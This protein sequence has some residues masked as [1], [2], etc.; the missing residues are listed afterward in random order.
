MINFDR[1]FEGGAEFL[2]RWN[3]VFDKPDAYVALFTALLFVS[4]V[5]LWLATRG[6]F[7]I[8]RDSTRLARQEFNA[9]HRPKIKVHAAELKRFPPETKRDEDDDWDRLGA[10][11]VC[12]NIGESAA[13]KIEIRGQILA[14]AGFAIDVQR[15]VAKEINEVLSGQKF[16][17]E[18]RSEIPMHDVAAARRLGTD[19]HCVG[20]IAYWDQNGLRRETGFCFRAD[21][22]DKQRERWVSAEKPEYEYDY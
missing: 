5:A 14:G 16:R 17:A 8:T 21:P 15:P 1:V 10:D 7:R 13:L 12:F 4:T 9:T 6:L 22:W 20:W 18:I 19:Y 3:E 2:R 11:L